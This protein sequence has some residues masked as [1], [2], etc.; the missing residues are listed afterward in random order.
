MKLYLSFIILYRSSSVGTGPGEWDLETLYLGCWRLYL[1]LSI[2]FGNT[3]Y[4]WVGFLFYNLNSLC[5]CC[6][7]V[8]SCAILMLFHHVSLPQVGVNSIILYKLLQVTFTIYG[9]TIK[10]HLFTQNWKH[11]KLHSFNCNLLLRKVKKY[12][13]FNYNSREHNWQCIPAMK[14]II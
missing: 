12:L 1:L 8:Q 11:C 9:T 7:L 14:P 3:T 10:M 13:N 6:A 2:Q 4:Y 5:T